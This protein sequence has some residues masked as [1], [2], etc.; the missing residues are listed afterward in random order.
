MY[1]LGLLAEPDSHIRTL[2]LTYG[3]SLDLSAIL[4]NVAQMS[5]LFLIFIIDPIFGWL[6]AAPGFQALGS[7][8]NDCVNHDWEE[9]CISCGS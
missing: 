7:D 8:G 3:W 4:P 9:T 2:R 5:L 6:Q 1:I